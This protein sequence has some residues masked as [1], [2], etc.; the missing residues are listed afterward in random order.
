MDIYVSKGGA[1]AGPYPED[2][3]RKMISLG[4]YSPSDLGWHAG[5]P[6]WQPLVNI[7]PRLPAP[8]MPLPPGVSPEFNPTGKATTGF[9]LGLIGMI[10]WIIPLFG[11]PITIIG[12]VMALKGLKSTSRGLAI[13]GVTLSIIGLVLTVINASIGAYMGATGQNPFVNKMMHQ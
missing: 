3:V 11:L 1:Q 6:G 12:L 9:V 4:Q 2:E 13:A 8:T 7:L 5:L 10:A